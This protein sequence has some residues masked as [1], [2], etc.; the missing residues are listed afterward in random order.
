MLIASFA[1]E[2]ALWKWTAATG[3]WNSEKFPR[4]A[5]EAPADRHIA[6]K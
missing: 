6:K 2:K 4:E 3:T 1:A 5:Q